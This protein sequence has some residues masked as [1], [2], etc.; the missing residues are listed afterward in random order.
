MKITSLRGDLPDVS[1]KKEPLVLNRTN[2]NAPL[3]RF[4]ADA[5]LFIHDLLFIGWASNQ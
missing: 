1:A 5:T 4:L 3:A 2:E